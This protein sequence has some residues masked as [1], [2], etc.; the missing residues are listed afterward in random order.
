MNPRPAAILAAVALLSCGETAR[1]AGPFRIYNDMFFKDMPIATSCR[2]AN[3]HIIYENA[4]WPA[5]RDYGLL[6]SQA[7]FTAVVRAHKG[8]HGPIVLDI[9]RLPLSG[10]RR[11][12]AARETLLAKLA[13]WTHA[14]APGRVV[15][16]FGYNTLTD[17]RPEYRAYAQ[18]L[19]QHVDAFFPPMYT[20]GDDRAAW[21][22]RA[23]AVVSEDR[24]YAE[25]KPIFFYLWPQYDAHT[26]KQFHWISRGYWRYELATSL[27]FAD[28][29]V[30]WGPTGSAWDISDGWWAATLS[31]L[32]RLPDQPLRLRT[33]ERASCAATEGLPSGLTEAVTDHSAP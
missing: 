22:R 20:R 14:A 17:V 8:R 1:A 28:G 31:F 13:D 33:A 9:E 26:P 10:G 2:L 18:A 6:P 19:A 32:R 11:T 24:S 23:E 21:A 30:L 29:I 3:S 25:N 15:G 5:D 4:I 7:Q 12:A 27:R 16:Y